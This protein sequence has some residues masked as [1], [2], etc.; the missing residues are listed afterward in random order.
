M[1]PGFKP[2]TFFVFQVCLSKKVLSIC[3]HAEAFVI[4]RGY[5]LLIALTLQCSLCKW[6]KNIPPHSQHISAKTKL[7]L[8]LSNTYFPGPRLALN[9][10]FFSGS[11]AFSRIVFSVIFKSI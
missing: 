9:L 8:T 7:V 11:K 3:V 6:L 10:G 2:F 1:T 5:N 4:E